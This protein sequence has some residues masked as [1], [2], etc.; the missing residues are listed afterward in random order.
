MKNTQIF[1]T[2]SEQWAAVT[3]QSAEIMEP[4]HMWNPDPVWIDTCHGI[5]PATAAVPPTIL[6]PTVVRSL[7]D[8]C[9]LKGVAKTSRILSAHLL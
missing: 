6:P 1:N 4:P 2:Y 7:A 3:I 9:R 5:S 8:P